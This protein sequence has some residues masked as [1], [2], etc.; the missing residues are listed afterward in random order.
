MDIMA[1]EPEIVFYPDDKGFLVTSRP[2]PIESEW[3][4]HV[5]INAAVLI[6]VWDKTKK[7]WNVEPLPHYD[8]L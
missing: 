4:I 1:D 6:A 8:A 5:L 3:P 7:L 2:I